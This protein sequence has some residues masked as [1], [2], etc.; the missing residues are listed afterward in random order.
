MVPDVRSVVSTN[1][2]QVLKRQVQ[3]LTHHQQKLEA[4]LTQI[5][6]KYNQKKRK[7]LASS[8]DFNRV[9]TID[10]HTCPYQPCFYRVNVFLQELKKHCSKVVDEKKYTEMVAEQVLMRVCL[11]HFYLR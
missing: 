6:E 3:S 10:T 8:E 7:F 9:I 1:R 4:E 11:I 2:M 5:E